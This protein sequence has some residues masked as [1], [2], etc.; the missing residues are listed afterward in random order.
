MS[1]LPDERAIT[2]LYE[3]I[4]QV[5]AQA[6]GQAYRAVNSSM[7]GAYW[8]VGRLIVEQ[9]QQGEERAAY[10][11]RL[12]AELAARLTQT[13]GRGFDETNLRKMRQFYLVF[14]NRDAASRIRG[15]GR[16]TSHRA[17]RFA[18]LSG[19]PGRAKLGTLPSTHA[20]RGRAC[21]H[22]VHERGRRPRLEHEA[23]QT[24]KES[25]R[26]QTRLNSVSIAAAVALVVPIT[27][28]D[29]PP[30]EPPHG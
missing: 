14:S 10:G 26:M 27:T 3:N 15:H 30:K 2:Q 22:L 21:P 5:L 8:E 12:L 6:R 9:M 1:G 25:S 13:F 11:H 16:K 29:S 24:A 4:C 28:A 19:P 20:R 17:S 18:V 23:A 7:V